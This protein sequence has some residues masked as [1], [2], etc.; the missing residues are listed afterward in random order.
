MKNR[1][2]ALVP[3]LLLTVVLCAQQI[4]LQMPRPQFSNPFY[5]NFSR[6]Y[7][8]ATAA[9]RGYTG[10]AT[11]GDSDNAL[12]NPAAAKPDSA[13]FYLELD[14]KPP[15]EAEGYPMYANYTSPAPISLVG[16]ST[17]FGKDFSGALLY[18]VPKSI[19]LDDF[20]F[21]INQGND[22]VQR[23]PTYYLHRLSTNLAYHREN[24]HVGLNLHSEIHYYDDPIFLQTYDRVRDYQFSFRV[25]PGLLYKHGLWGIGYTLL[26]PTKYDWDMKYAKY[27]MLDPLWMSGGLS[28]SN[29]G[30]AAHLEA[31]WEQTSAVDDHFDDRMIF[32]AGAE[33]IQ[34]ALSYRLGYMYG[35]K[36]YSGYIR[37][38]HNL[39]EPDTSIFWNDVPDSL[40]VKDS[41]Q[42][43]LTLGLSYK[44]KRGSINLAAMQT[45]VAEV[46]RTQI[47]ISLSFYLSTFTRKKELYLND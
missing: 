1:L 33:K 18:N 8:N 39:A 17:N 46:P 25:Q 47:S 28:Y 4:P 31:E 9:G 16:L 29:P 12:L 41:S 30:Y 11:L 37:L 24:L 45:I 27:N 36:V 44:H 10:L 14:I 42:H 35:S 20:S 26:P 22:F 13:S 23:F 34:G 6:N 43:A 3:L 19:T 40:Y 21:Y 32:K 7:V 15:I 2:W 5:D 38:P